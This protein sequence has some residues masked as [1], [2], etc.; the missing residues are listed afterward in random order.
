MVAIVPNAWSQAAIPLN[1][2]GPWG[3]LVTALI[4]SFLWTEG[5]R[6][7]QFQRPRGI[8]FGEW[9]ILTGA[10]Q[11]ISALVFRQ[12]SGALPRPIAITFGYGTIKMAEG[13]KENGFGRIITIEYDPE[14]YAKAKQRIEDSGLADWIEVRNQSSL[15]TQIDGT[16]DF[17]YSDSLLKIREQEIRK[18]LPQLDGRSLIAIHDASLHFAVVREGALRLE[19]EG[20]I[21]VILLPTPRGLVLAQKREGRK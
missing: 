16:I 9:L 2:P 6:Q 7:I 3:V 19:Q 5:R 18:F 4:F 13:L 1:T 8:V 15:D 17:L 14:I 20:P 10:C 11:V 12:I 21:S